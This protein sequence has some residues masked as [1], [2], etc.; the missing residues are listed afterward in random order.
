MKA[1]KKD[2]NVSI[3]F[4]IGTENIGTADRYFTQISVNSATIIETTIST[5][6]YHR[7]FTYDK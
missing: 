6:I 2:K 5:A 7:Y 1:Q 3:I 4:K